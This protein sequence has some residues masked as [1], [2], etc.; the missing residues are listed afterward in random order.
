M[1]ITVCRDSH[2]YH[3]PKKCRIGVQKLRRETSIRKQILSAIKILENQT[4][5]LRALNDSLFDHAPLVGRNQ[6]GNNIDFPRT[7]CPER[8]A[9]YVVRD[10]VLADTALGANAASP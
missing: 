7:V 6:E 10:A 1:K 4:Q 9:V 3:R 2:T 8:V 5:Q